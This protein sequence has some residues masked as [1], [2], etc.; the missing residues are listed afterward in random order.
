MKR[1]FTKILGVGLTLALLVSMLVTAVPAAAI[2][3]ADQEAAVIAAA[4]RLVDV[5]NTEDG[6]FPWKAADPPTAST[7]NC[8]GVTAMGIMEAWK[9]AP[10]LEYEMALALAYKFVVDKEPVFAWVDGK[11]TE[12]A[13]GVAGVDS[14]PD[15]TFLLE[16]ASAANSN[17]GLLAAIVAQVAGTEPET[18][19]DLAKSRWDGRVNHLG[20]AFE[21][22]PAPTATAMAQYLRDVVRHPDYD[23]ILPWDLAQAIEAALALDNVYPGEGYDQQALD[24]AG[25]LYA[26]VD[27]GAG[28]YFISTDDNQNDYILGL[29]GA[30]D[31][32]E[33]LNIHPIEV[34]AYLDLLLDKQQPG[35]YWNYYRA[36]DPVEKGVQS[37]AYAA[38]ALFKEGS[39][40]ARTAANEATNWLVSS[41]QEGGWFDDVTP[42]V[43]S[44]TECYEVNG[45]AAW[46]L[47]VIGA[48]NIE[49]DEDWYK[50][51][52][53]VYV[54]V[55]DAAVNDPF[56]VDMVEV[57][58]VSTID[59]FGITLTLTETDINTGVFKGSFLL[60]P[61]PIEGR[62][63]MQ[64]VVNDGD[65]VTVTY[66]EV[67]DTATVDD[68]APVIYDFS[69]AD[70]TTIP[71]AM[72]VI[73]AA[74][75]DDVGSGIDTATGVMFVD[76]LEV[77]ADVTESNISYTPGEALADDIHIVTVDV[78]DVVGN[79]ATQAIWSFTVDSTKP[80][81]ETVSLDPGPPYIYTEGGIITF[82][83][84]FSE[85]MDPSVE[86]GAAFGL[87]P[88]YDTNNVASIGW[89][90]ANK[91][92]GEFDI[93]P[94]SWDPAW[95]GEQTL[96]VA[97]AQDLAGNVMVEDTS[98]TFVI[99]LN[100]PYA[101]EPSYL[102]VTQSPPDT[103]D[104]VYGDPGAVEAGATV[105]VWADLGLTTLID[106][107]SANPNG[108]FAAIEIGDNQYGEVWVTAKD[109]VGHRSA[110]T[111]LQNDIDA[112]EITWL[113][114]SVNGGKPPWIL[115]G[116]K[117][118]VTMW[119]EAGCTATFDILDV[120]IGGAAE[121]NP[122]VSGIYE[123]SHTVV[124]GDDVYWAAMIGWLMDAYG[125]SNHWRIL[126]AFSIDTIVPTIAPL[127][128]AEGA[129]VNTA[130]PE[131][132]AV[133][134][135]NL[136]GINSGSIAMTVDG[137][138]V[139]AVYAD[140]VVSYTPAIDLAEGSHTVILDVSDVAGNPT[141][142]V[143]WFFAVD[144]IDPVITIHPVDTPTDV[145][146]QFITGNWIEENLD[147]MTLTVNRV[148]VEIDFRTDIWSTVPVDASLDQGDNLV[149]A[150]ITDMAGNSASAE[151]TINLDTEDPV[152]TVISPNG[153]E[154]LLGGNMYNIT[155]TASDANFI[156]D[157]I[158]IEYSV[159]S[160][161][162]WN[163]VATSEMNDGGYLWSVPSLDSSECL[164][165]VTGADSLGKSGSDVSDAVFT[166]TTITSDNL[167]PAVTVNSPNGGESW[168]GGGGSTRTI[169]WTATDD[170]TPSGSLLVDLYFSPNGGTVWNGIATSEVNNGAYSWLVPGIN[171]SQCL[172]RVVVTDTSG[173]EGYDVSDNVFTI[174]TPEAPVNTIEL[175]RTG[176]NLISLMLIPTSSDITDVLAGIEE[177]VSVWAYDASI[178]DPDER[179]SFYVPEPGLGDLEKMVDGKGYWIEMQGPHGDEEEY[180]EIV[181]LTI[182]GQELPDPPD[183]PPA[184]SVVEGWNLIGFKSTTPRTVS[185]YLLAIDGK[186]TIVR[187]YESAYFA[188][189]FDLEAGENL[190]PGSGYW[191]SITEPGTIYP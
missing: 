187:G 20:A 46:A 19:S 88:G 89:D 2:T 30:I 83:L 189:Y 175:K 105:E 114:W 157:P 82:T 159:D 115:E 69:P 142:Q 66:L 94:F 170:K 148:P 141:A 143:S 106:S 185:S 21:D 140:G 137:A 176:W 16:L 102:H 122:G 37:T 44:T 74:L 129:F 98:T 61:P 183:A 71:N 116:Q 60:I 144:T 78:S 186:Y 131:I 184:Y 35:G 4:D 126:M 1:K 40:N 145:D 9:V 24:I 109:A 154:I 180:E 99:D 10:S 43:I 58:A 128:P 67:T 32:Y 28:T 52:D 133:L 84:T 29:A 100:P 34:A 45:E 153:G 113:D 118:D 42:E 163:D 85:P 104:N 31:A 178:E 64:V 80:T 87:P 146:T 48:L 81:I 93:D 56:Q 55:E 162:S 72:P 171:S 101:P 174:T 156:T 166:I 62:V 149:V 188:T 121:T 158:T 97:G 26:S 41:Q 23:A 107:K 164:I 190:D 95:D 127:T 63:G 130:T 12:K 112:P 132:S 3:T 111:Q 150:T 15:V 18:I 70:G 182:V 22:D 161:T 13:P 59:T 135:D 11:Y 151:A 51:D 73:S 53:T 96:W 138:S 65:L 108:S 25:V 6:G 92:I 75:A 167:A 90:T 91:W 47:A 125:N 17:A 103:L 68:A 147:T 160:G 76:G 77:D 173:N 8:Q 179:W 120:A 79:A 117:I 54:T 33:Q 172:V 136:S 39:D 110:A 86:P 119:G 155:W 49:L 14:F 191:I 36:A 7:T 50:T 165:R 139:T 123:G 177:V 5:Q 124:A 169:T 134:N 152:V 181:T 27:D 38:L 168:L 57:N